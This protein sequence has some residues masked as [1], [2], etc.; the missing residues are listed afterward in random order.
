M[1][2]FTK[3]ADPLSQRS[4]DLKNEIA[5]LESKIKKL[6][7]QVEQTS[8]AQNS[9]LLVSLGPSAIA[10]TEPIFE[11]TATPRLKGE[12]ESLM[13]EE[14]YNEL[15]LRKF[16]LPALLRRMQH[17]VRPQTTANA[18]LVSYL[19]AGSMQGLRPLRYEKRVARNRFVILAGIFLLI[20]WGLAAVFLRR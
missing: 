17:Q 11:Q 18:K 13:T 12:N 6:S 15:G 4:R 10:L 16:D 2:L 5:A 8:G 1:G 14:H 19:A 3:K 7:S 20:L 9:G